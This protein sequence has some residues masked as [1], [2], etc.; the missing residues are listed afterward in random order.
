MYVLVENLRL[1]LESEEVQ[2]AANGG[3]TFPNGN[4]THQV[5]LFLGQRFLNN[6][7]YDFLYNSGG[8]GYVLNKAALKVLVTSALPNC[9]YR[10]MRTPS[11]DVAIS[12]CLQPSGVFP[13]YTLDEDGGQ[14]FNHFS[15]Q[16]YL[17]EALDLEDDHWITRWTTKDSK[18]NM[19]H[20]SNYSVSFHY[21][22]PTV[23]K[24]MHAILY[25]YCNSV[26]R[27]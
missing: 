21:I 14:R 18:N 3:F 23:M 22:E 10:H 16:F 19:D 4:E 11:E 7:D 17:T 2:I 15:P 9:Q 20:F 27:T 13:F 6:G 1:Y 25:G 8:P 24:Q 5:P 26:I 12:K